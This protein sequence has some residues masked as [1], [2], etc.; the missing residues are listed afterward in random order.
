MTTRSKKKPAPVKRAPRRNKPPS[1]QDQLNALYNMVDRIAAM[2]LSLER[3]VSEIS[4]GPVMVG[5]LL[6]PEIAKLAPGEFFSGGQS[7]IV[8]RGTSH[9][10][11]FAPQIPL[12]GFEIEASGGAVITDVKIGSRSFM[13]SYP[14][15][16]T[17][18]RFGAV[19]VG[20]IVSV[21]V[22]VLGSGVKRIW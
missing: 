21:V 15:S 16:I 1:V 14:M 7:A 19:E 6:K 11:M 3:L 5:V 8:A 17:R 18:G 13:F 9:E 10:F 4:N 2:N 20:Q 12:T 22:E